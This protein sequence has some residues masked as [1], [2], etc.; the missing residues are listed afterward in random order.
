[1]DRVSQRAL[2]EVFNVSPSGVLPIVTGQRWGDRKRLAKLCATLGYRRGAEIGVR[3]GGF[4]EVFCREMPG[5]EMWCVDPWSPCPNYSQNR[6]DRHF[7]EAVKRLSPYDVRFV[8]KTSMDALTDV[9][10]DLDFI[11]IDGRHEF[12][13]VMM[14]LLRW[15]PKVRRGGLVAAHDYHLADVKHAVDAY[16]RAH[17]VDPWYVLKTVQ[18]TAFWIQP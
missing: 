10:D 11:H 12:D 15:C 17:H 1:M 18:P 13:F 9:P 6:Q 5:L 7:S 14:D 8:K 3:S 2:K 16:T 4:S